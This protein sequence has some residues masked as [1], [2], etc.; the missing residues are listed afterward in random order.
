MI[1]L[2]YKKNRLSTPLYYVQIPFAKNAKYHGVT[3]SNKLKFTKHKQDIHNRGL[4]MLNHI[5]HNS[6]LSTTL[7]K[8][9]IR[10]YLNSS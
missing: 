2:N 1:I 7:K 3:I 9:L 4:A 6:I 8:Q 10:A 5:R